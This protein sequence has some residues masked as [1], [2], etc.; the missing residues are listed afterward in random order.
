MHGNEVFITDIIHSSEQRSKIGIGWTF[1]YLNSVLG[2]LTR[3]KINHRQNQIISSNIL[4]S[5]CILGIIK[6]EF[7][8]ISIVSYSSEYS[9]Q[10]FLL[11]IFL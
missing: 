7:E 1:H 11:S 6:N 8:I 2:N 4:P 5:T 10:Y 9:L 3:I